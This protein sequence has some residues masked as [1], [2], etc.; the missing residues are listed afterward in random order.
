MACSSNGGA[1]RWIDQ[2]SSDVDRA[3][4]V[5]RLAE[6]VQDAAEGLAADR[7]RDRRAGVDGLHAA[8]HAVGRLHGDAA[9][10]VLAD[11]VRHF[12][13]DVDGHL[14]ELAVVDDADGVVDRRK[15]SFLE[16]DVDGR[17]DDLDDPGR[18]VAVVRLPFC[19]PLSR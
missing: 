9:D 18:S 3:A 4:L 19:S 10:L 12:D 8:D 11:V 16:L 13:D 2:R 14:S 1:S 15:M 5:D 6:D 17:A 7:H